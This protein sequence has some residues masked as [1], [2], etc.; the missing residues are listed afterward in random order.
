MHT[1]FIRE[2][3]ELERHSLVCIQHETPLHL[4]WY[5]R[6]CYKN[7]QFIQILIPFIGYNNID[8]V[9][10]DSLSLSISHYYIMCVSLCAYL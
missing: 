8:T 7:C 1:V 3:A 4:C 10:S 2:E 6:S 9:S 5:L